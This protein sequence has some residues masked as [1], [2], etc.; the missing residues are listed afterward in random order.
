PVRDTVAIAAQLERRGVTLIGPNCPGVVSVDA[1]NVGITPNDIFTP[2]PVGVV[3]R[4]GTLMYR[5]ILD[6]SQAGLGQ[7][8][9]CGMGGDPVHGVGFIEC[10]ERFEADPATRAV[11]LIG[12]IGGDDEERAAAYV[13]EHVTKPVIAH[14]VGFT[15][16]PGKQMGH[17]GAIIFGGAGTAAAKAEALEA[18]GI[19]VARAPYDL[20]ALVRAALS[21]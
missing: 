5:I 6:L 11:V 1:C 19:A 10:L 13:R 21:G 17:A 8:T 18:A 15:A 7:T 12:E 2:G 16:P 4:S 20:P 14:L 3:S 9:C